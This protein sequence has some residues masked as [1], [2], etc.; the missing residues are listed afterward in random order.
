[1]KKLIAEVDGQRSEFLMDPDDF[2]CEQQ[3]DATPEYKVGEEK[4][5]GFKVSPAR[6]TAGG[7]YSEVLFSESVWQNECRL[8]VTREGDDGK[9]NTIS[10]RRGEMGLDHIVRGQRSALSF[11]VTIESFDPEGKHE[12]FS[13]LEGVPVRVE[14]FR[15]PEGCS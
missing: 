2:I 13:K 14:I 15:V 8:V 11:R 3:R 9:P 1:M 12:V 4:P 5:S 10:S 7:Q 6:V